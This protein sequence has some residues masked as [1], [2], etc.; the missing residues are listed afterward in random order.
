[1]LNLFAAYA[2]EE[3]TE[4]QVVE[5]RPSTSRTSS[6]PRKKKENEPKIFNLFS[7]ENML[8]PQKAYA[9]AAIFPLREDA[10]GAD[11]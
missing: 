5:T 2:D 9:T 11:D 8:F 6:S 4:V 3:E 10:F 1:M 7:Q